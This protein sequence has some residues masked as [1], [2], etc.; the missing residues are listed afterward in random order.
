[1]TQTPLTPPAGLPITMSIVVMEVAKRVGLPLVG[2]NLPG[3]WFAC[4]DG[5][6]AP[7]TFELIASSG[8]GAGPSSTNEAR[9]KNN[10]RCCA[11]LPQATSW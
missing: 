10:A 9:N 3:E 4:K 11:P 7:A 2:C 8:T 6:S 1:M 5:S